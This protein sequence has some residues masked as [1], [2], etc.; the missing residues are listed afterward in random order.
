M[1]MKK[2]ERKVVMQ[3]FR[4]SYHE[5][6]A[7]RY[8]GA[9]VEVVPCLNFDEMFKMMEMDRTLSG[10]VAIENTVSGSILPNYT[11]IKDSGTFVSGECKLR[12]SMNLLAYPGQSIDDILEVRSHPLA[13]LQCKDFFNNYPTISLIDSVDTALSAK[14]ISETG[15]LGSGVVASKLAAELYGLE[16]LAEGIES[17]T[18]NFTRFLI[19]E[20]KGDN[21]KREHKFMDGINKASIVFKLPHRKGTLVELLSGF[22]ENGCSLTTIQSNPIIGVEWEYLFFAD[23]L[24]DNYERYQ[25]AIEKA[26]TLCREFG[27]IGEYKEGKV[28]M[29]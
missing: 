21:S 5:I 26:S 7:R 1:I 11:L 24:F 2:T 17:N 10:I 28:F 20:P 14:E 15:L 4:G 27:I 12:I 16:M 22:S 25:K 23:M 19:L 9:D 8:F 29:D 13:L 6:A 3:G 18:R